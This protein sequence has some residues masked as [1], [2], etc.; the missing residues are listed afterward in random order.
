VRTTKASPGH[1]RFKLTEGGHRQDG[2]GELPDPGLILNR[3]HLLPKGITATTKPLVDLLQEKFPARD[4]APLMA[5][6]A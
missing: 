1:P 6:N 4:E 5:P 3:L 2:P